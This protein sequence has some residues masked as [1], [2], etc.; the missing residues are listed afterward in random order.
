M[1][2]LDGNLTIF[3]D[4]V[5][6]ELSVDYRIAQKSKPGTGL[7]GMCDDRQRDQLFSPSQMEVA[8]N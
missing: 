2:A 5:N 3:Y 8:Q 7:C 1:S 4:G 6:V